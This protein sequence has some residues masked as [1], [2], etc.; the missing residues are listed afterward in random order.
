GTFMDRKTTSVRLSDDA[1]EL[2]T[3]L[4][5]KL[6]VARGGIVELAIRRLAQAE[7]VALP[8]KDEST[9]AKK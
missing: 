6:G 7:Y 2:I 3:A 8:A 9:K 5:K 4:S 1:K